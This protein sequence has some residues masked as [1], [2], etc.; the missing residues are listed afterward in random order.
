L[1]DPLRCPAN[2]IET[3]LS[4]KHLETNWL[5]HPSKIFATKKLPKKLGP[6]QSAHRTALRHIVAQNM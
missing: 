6:S 2:D 3:N 5:S 1:S 4:K